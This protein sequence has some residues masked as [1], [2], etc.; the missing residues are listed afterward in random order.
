[1]EYTQIPDEMLKYALLVLANE[2]LIPAN[3]NLTA[4]RVRLK[5]TQQQIKQQQ[6]VVLSA[7]LPK[8]LVVN[9]DNW[10]VFVYN[11]L[12][13]RGVPEFFIQEAFGASSGKSV[14]LFNS[15]FLGGEGKLSQVFSVSL[16]NIVP[17]RVMESF[18]LQILASAKPAVVPVTITLPTILSKGV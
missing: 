9:K 7:V 5:P 15:K 12:F 4:E 17:N 13:L 1:M 18:S 3:P 6:P 11:H 2:G 10:G 16:W 14:N 8:T